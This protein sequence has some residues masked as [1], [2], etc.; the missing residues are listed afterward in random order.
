MV[1]P[2]G[3]ARPYQISGLARVN[4]F[5]FLWSFWVVYWLGIVFSLFWGFFVD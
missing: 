5:A 4:V 3:T 2:G 1:M